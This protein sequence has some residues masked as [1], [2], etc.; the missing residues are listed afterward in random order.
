MRPEEVALK[1]L[2]HA[3]RGAEASPELEARLRGAFRN[4]KTRTRIRTTGWKWVPIRAAAAAALVVIATIV[5]RHHHSLP[6]E[7]ARAVLQPA[8]AVQMATAGTRVENTPGPVATT[9]VKTGR[10]RTVEQPGEIVTEF[11]PLAG[12]MTPVDDGE[13]LRVTLPASAMREVG[14]PVRE[15]RLMERVQADV[16]VSHGMATAVRFVKSSE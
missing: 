4:R 15:D 3:D 1:A 6:V 8:P 7:R 16:L 2:A 14:L 10:V 5:S 11:F 9:R 13:L 12:Y